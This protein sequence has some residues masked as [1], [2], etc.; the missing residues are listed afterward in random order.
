MRW[1]G[2]GVSTFNDNKQDP[3]QGL[4]TY[5]ALGGQAMTTQLLGGIQAGVRGIGSA[6]GG[7]VQ[8]MRA[9]KQ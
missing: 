9:A 4:T 7:L 5:A 3:T 8:A 2:S 6:G 1:I